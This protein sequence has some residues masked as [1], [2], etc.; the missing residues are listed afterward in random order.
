MLDLIEKLSKNIDNADNSKKLTGALQD[1]FIK[2]FK[3]TRFD[4][5][6]IDDKDKS[7]KDFS[8]DWVNPDCAGIDDKFQNIVTKL[9]STKYI[10]DY[11][12]LLFFAL[13]KSSKVIGFIKIEGGNSD[14]LIEFLQ[15]AAFIISIKIQNILHQVVAV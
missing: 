14:K 9:K 5:Y 1:F 6:I 11:K 7:I 10:T 4:I 8:K 13:T 15:T 3:V 12:D 2:N